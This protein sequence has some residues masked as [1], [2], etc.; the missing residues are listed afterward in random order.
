MLTHSRLK[1][2]VM[3]MSLKLNKYLL[4]ASNGMILEEHIRNAFVRQQMSNM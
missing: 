4:S 2:E 1:S 3:S